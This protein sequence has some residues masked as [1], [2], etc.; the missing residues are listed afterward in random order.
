MENVLARKKKEINSGARVYKAKALCKAPKYNF[1]SKD[2]D[3]FHSSQNFEDL[4]SHGAVNTFPRR[5]R[6]FLN[7]STQKNP[8]AHIP[9]HTFIFLL[10]GMRDDEE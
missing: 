5:L 1:S 3:F 7:I 4:P 8:T 10:G 9:P 2:P 6:F